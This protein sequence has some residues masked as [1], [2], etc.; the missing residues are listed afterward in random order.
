M[1]VWYLFTPPLGS[2]QDP[3]DPNQY[4]LYVVGSKRPVNT[5]TTS[6]I[7][8]INTFVG[9]YGLPILDQEICKEMHKAIQYRCDSEHIIL[10]P[11][12]FRLEGID[13]IWYHL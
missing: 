12:Y 2:K 13:K 10:R 11:E 8:A 9:E 3:L 6:Q 7:Y 5:D 1:R 4:T